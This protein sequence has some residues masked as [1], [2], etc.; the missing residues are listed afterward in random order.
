MKINNIATESSVLLDGCVTKWVTISCLLESFHTAECEWPVVAKI[1]D[2]T[3]R[4]FRQRTILFDIVKRPL[5][6]RFLRFQF[7]FH[8]DQLDTVSKK[9]L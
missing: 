1:T 9:D 8:E 5:N 4:Y 2:R 7:H 6:I 3:W